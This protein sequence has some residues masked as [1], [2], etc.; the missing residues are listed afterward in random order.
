MNAIKLHNADETIDDLKAL[1]KAEADKVDECGVNAVMHAWQSGQHLLAIKKKLPH[2]EFGDWLRDN[3]DRDRST[4][5]RYMDLGMLK[6]AR[7][8]LLTSV[9]E[10]LRICQEEAKPKIRERV[11]EF[12][13]NNPDCTDDQI[14]EALDEKPASVRGR[15]NELCKDG[16]VAKSGEIPGDKK[17]LATYRAVPP[18]EVG[19]EYEDANEE[20]CSLQD[21]LRAASRCNSI[22]AEYLADKT[23]LKKSEVGGWL[24]LSAEGVGYKAVLQA[25]KKYAIHKIRIKSDAQKIKEVKSYS[26]HGDAT[27]TE[28]LSEK[29]DSIAN[30][31]E[32]VI[33]LY[34]PGCKDFPSW[35]RLPEEDRRNLRFLL[36]N[37]MAKVNEQF[38]YFL[39]LIEE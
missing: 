13:E 15:R 33:R 20:A 26:L 18:E 23:G 21:A 5:F 29:L 7:M 2:G 9:N 11:L 17:S 36:T 31:I 39:G 22:N 1:A 4:A 12:I 3:W 19:L 14:T 24:K 30:T 37:A 25:D 27:P 10:A 28:H 16:L 6:V 34:S 32:G 38:P 8:R 35:H